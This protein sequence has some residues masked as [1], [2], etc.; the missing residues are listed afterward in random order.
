MGKSL[1]DWSAPSYDVNT[2]RSASSL[3]EMGTG[4]KGNHTTRVSAQI[5]ESMG[6]GK[7]GAP[8]VGAMNKSGSADSGRRKMGGSDLP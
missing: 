6:G 1:R 3:E 7:A 8:G 5:E 4:S 2:G